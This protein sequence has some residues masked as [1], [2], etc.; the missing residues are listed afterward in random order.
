MT[1]LDSV[2]RHSVTPPAF[3][4][5]KL[6]RE[7]LVD[8]IHANTPRKLI[9]IATPAGYGK[10]TLLA[11]FSAQTELPVC[12]VRITEADRDV[13]RFANVLALSLQRRFRRLW[14]K[15]DLERLSDSSPQALA[16]A[17]ADIID[18]N[19][20]ETFVIALDD[21]HYINRSKATTT[22]I[23]AFL[24]VLPEQ[25]LK[26]LVQGLHAVLLSG[27]DGRVHLGHLVLS[28]QVADGGCTDHDFVRSD[29]SAANLT[30]QCLR[31]DGPQ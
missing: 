7:R 25:V 18:A 30:Q 29:A 14:G 6:N 8:V 12:S 28:N 22:F 10:T 26:V 3:D 31:D 17:F 2:L 15:F 27:L 20:S 11:N 21:V 13:M 24:E 23:D 4:Q 16:R 1:S 9:V 19:V 5:T